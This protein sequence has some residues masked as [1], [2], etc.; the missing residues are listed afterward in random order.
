MRYTNDRLREVLGSLL[1][2]PEAKRPIIIV[3]ADEGPYPAAYQHL[4][5]AFDWAS[6]TPDQLEEKYGI[7]D[8]MYLPGPPG[9]E[10]VPSTLSSVNTFR[11]LFRRYFGADLPDLPDRSYTSTKAEPYDF[12]DITD[13]LPSLAP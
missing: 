7:L 5:D 12:L 1:A 8:A 6:A 11:L 3:R 4:G 2:L 10:P 9:A 13:R